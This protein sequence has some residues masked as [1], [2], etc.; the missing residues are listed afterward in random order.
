MKL[1]FIR[2]GE[3]APPI[4]KVPKYGCVLNIHIWGGIFF[5]GRVLSIENSKLFATESREHPP[6]HTHCFSWSKGL[7][8][9]A[10]LAVQVWGRPKGLPLTVDK[11]VPLWSWSAEG[12]ANHCSESEFLASPAG[13]LLHM[14][15]FGV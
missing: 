3:G 2:L 8:K 13:F 12:A 6:T 11:M 5:S 10:A 4:V 15:N 7:P 14:S 1:Q 9:I